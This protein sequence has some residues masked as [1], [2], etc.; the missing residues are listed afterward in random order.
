MQNLSIEGFQISPQ[1]KRLWFLSEQRKSQCY[2][3]QC[4]ILIEGSINYSILEI[5]IEEVINRTEIFGLAFR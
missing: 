3:V 4:E 5:A 2:R 1:Q